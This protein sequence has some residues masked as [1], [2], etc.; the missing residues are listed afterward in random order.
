MNIPRGVCVV[1]IYDGRAYMGGDQF[2]FRPTGMRFSIPHP[3]KPDQ[4]ILFG[5]E[6]VT[7]LFHPDFWPAP[8]APVV[9]E[10]TTENP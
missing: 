7:I 4:Q 5:L 9:Q 1:P 2:M 6:D 8:D 10:S 3:D